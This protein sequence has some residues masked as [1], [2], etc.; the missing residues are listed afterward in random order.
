MQINLTG[1]LTSK[2]SEF[3]IA[4]WK[5]LLEAQ[6]SPGGIPKTFVDEKK[7]EM[8][9]AREKDTRS[10]GEADRRARLDEIRDR[11]RRERDGGGRGRGRGRGG[12]GRGGFDERSGRGRDSGWGGRGGG[13]SIMKV[14][15][16]LVYFTHLSFNAII[17]N[18]IPLAFPL[19]FPFTRSSAL[20]F[21]APQDETITFDYTPIQSR[22]SQKLS[23]SLP[24]SHSE[25]P[26]FRVI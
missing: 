9:R 13:V 11:E 10:L 1:F 2:T 18:E 7:E 14:C 21:T 20:C 16:L 22:R 23:L 4:L 24:L 6:S 19:A 15:R 5:L 26:S 25:T 12:R 8:R 3:M 17:A